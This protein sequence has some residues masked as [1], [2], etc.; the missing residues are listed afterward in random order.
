MRILLVVALLTAC[1]GGDLTPCEVTA[2]DIVL[3]SGAGE[4]RIVIDDNGLDV[5]SPEYAN[6]YPGLRCVV[7]MPD[8]S[9]DL[10]DVDKISSWTS[11]LSG[12]GTCP[13]QCL[14]QEKYP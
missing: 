12:D 8:E 3:A 13:L 2:R 4:C 14:Q 1:G 6:S 9:I 7:L 10:G 11:N 5:C